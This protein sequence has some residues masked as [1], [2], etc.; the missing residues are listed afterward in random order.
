[1]SAHQ[2]PEDEFDEAGKNVPMGAHRA[3]PSQWKT[4]LPFLIVVIAVPL[5]AW[6]A[7]W[8][9]TGSGPKKEA[10]TPKPTVSQSA[11]ATPEAS[12][13]PKEENSP[14]PEPSEEQKPSEEP[15]NKDFPVS[16]LN[17]TGRNGLA[18]Q[19]SGK[20][21]DDGFTQVSNGNASE[22]IT[23]Q[24]TIYYGKDYEEAAKH[25]GEVLGISNLQNN[26]RAVGN[27]GIIIILKG[28]YQG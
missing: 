2:Y 28:D 14:T 16:V 18:A 17:G 11:S 1:M 20:L 4:V 27:A 3:R 26:D 8:Y 9:V 25:A 24:T 23:E 12:T 6:A 21:S 22:W 19:V 10:E 15:I 5:L 13:S 7:A